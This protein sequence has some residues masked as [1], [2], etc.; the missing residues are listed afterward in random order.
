MKK[1]LVLGAGMISRPLVAYLLNKGYNLTVADMNRQKSL[2]VTG[3]HESANA[4]ILDANN[5][6]EVEQLISSHDIVVSLL[7][8]TMHLPVAK[9]CIRQKRSL[10]T[11]SYQ[12]QGMLELKPLI[13]ESGITI[14]NEMGLDPGI[15]HM[16][17]RKIIDRVHAQQGQVHNFYSLCGALPAPEAAD[18][19][20]AYKFSWS[21]K[22]VMM[23]SLS[24][25][26]YLINGEVVEVSGDHL[27]YQPF[28]IDYPELGMLDV[29][30][31]RDSV[32]YI[33]E[34]GIEE[35]KTM[36][37]GTIRLPGW[38]ETIN[39]M[40][41]LGLLDQQAITMEHMSYFNLLERKLGTLYP[42]YEAQLAK[43]LKIDTTSSAI[44]SLRWLGFFSNE[45]IG[46]LVDSPFNVTCD[47]MFAKMML[48]PEDR[49]MVVMQHELLVKYP[50]NREERIIS[51]LLEYGDPTGDTA[52]ARTVA[53][54]AAIAVDLILTGQLTQTG[55]LRPLSAEIYEPV[56]KKLEEEGI[57][58]REEVSLPV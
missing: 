20:L 27:F 38:C 31:N 58:L 54:P 3:G 5:E 23:A 55:L 7:P 17:A 33:S 8:N 6:E 26:R 52:I 2:A 11:T 14:I 9:L 36:M 19:P 22:G 21:P 45:Q 40:K 13:E 15:D 25:A 28:R 57:V 4:V 24:N 18:N 41:Q 32:L 39:A 49:D 12:S 1:V 46:R 16:S 42:E 53:L 37:R 51:R 35:V 50:G 43:F 29:Y 30:P 56:L 44:K 10:V 34:Y 47:L 48:Q